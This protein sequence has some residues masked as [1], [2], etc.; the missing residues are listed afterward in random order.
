[1][2]KNDRLGQNLKLHLG[3]SQQKTGSK[4]KLHSVKTAYLK[5]K[6]ATGK[7]DYLLF[8]YITLRQLFTFFSGIF[9]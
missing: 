8:Y 1:M 9:A 6:S 3:L 7:D 5:L 2:L 4:N